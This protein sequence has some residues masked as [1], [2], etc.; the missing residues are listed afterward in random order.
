ME[1]GRMIIADDKTV[2]VGNDNN[3]CMRGPYSKWVTFS[4]C[5]LLGIWGFHKFYEGRVVWG[6]IYLFTLGLCFV[7]VLVDV[8]VILGKPNLYYLK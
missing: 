3:E 8:I 1:D 2:M 6:I 7:G 5:L 4:L